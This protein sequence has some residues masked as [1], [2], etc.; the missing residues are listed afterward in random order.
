M[1]ANKYPKSLLGRRTPAQYEF[2]SGVRGW[3]FSLVS[4]LI[5]KQA[6]ELAKALTPG[7][8]RF[9]TVERIVKMHGCAP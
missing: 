5:G 9:E 2:D 1:I 4:P 3:A 6:R 7:D 8:K